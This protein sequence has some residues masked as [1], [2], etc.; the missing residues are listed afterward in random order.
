MQKNKL[1]TVLNKKILVS[2]HNLIIITSLKIQNSQQIVNKIQDQKT[3][4][5]PK[6]IYF[7][8]RHSRMFHSLGFV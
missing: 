6:F 4:E 7:K 3:K 5:H 8:L 1:D 2:F